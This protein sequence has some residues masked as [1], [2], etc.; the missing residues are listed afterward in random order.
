[1]EISEVFAAGEMFR[2]CWIITPRNS[3][4][5]YDSS[6]T[7]AIL[8]GIIT[9]G[10]KLL[11]LRSTIREPGHKYYIQILGSCDRASLM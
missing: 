4:K 3:K 1:M 11:F 6:R 8:P 9:A 10:F 5:R 7:Y 2:E